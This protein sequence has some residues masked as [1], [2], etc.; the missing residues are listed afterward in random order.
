MK[1]RKPLTPTTINLEKEECSVCS[2][3]VLFTGGW[4]RPPDCVLLNERG[5]RHAREHHRME[6]TGQT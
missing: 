2:D 4:F 1:T 3:K 6:S 5:Y